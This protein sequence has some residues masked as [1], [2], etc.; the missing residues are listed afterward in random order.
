MLL[1]IE[2]IVSIFL[3]MALGFIANRVGVLP[4]EANDFLT[5]LLIKVIT[6]CMVFASI[7]SKEL[8]D[9]TV[10]ATIQVFF[11]A[12]VFFMVAA[13][14]GFLLSKYV[15]RAKPEQIGIYTFTYGS[16][17]SGFMGFPITLA[18]FGSEILY[19][20]VIHNITLTI[21]LYSIG[22]AI[23]ALCS[24]EKASFSWKTFFHSFLNINTIASVVSIFML[25]TGLHLPDFLFDTVESVSDATVP[26]SMLLVGMQ[27]GQT[28][29]LKMLANGKMVGLSLIKMLTLPVL[30][31]LAVNWLPLSVSV[32]V[33]MVFAA[34]FPAA[35]AT[36]PVVTLEGKDSIATAEI[37]AFTTLVSVATIP[38]F[39]TLITAYYSL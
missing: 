25:F 12:L 20:V 10:A 18:L 15:F 17:N 21:Y 35:V 4:K 7:T 37:V 3:I 26:V 5:N 38:I 14:I 36:V 28:N 34:V 29:P 16:I 39:A 1:I 32:K 33:A 13:L 11:G 6:P 2:K 8:E 22:P 9:D 27:L 31:F 24:G 23:L 19:F 30:T